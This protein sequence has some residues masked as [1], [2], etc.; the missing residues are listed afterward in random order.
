MF[1]VVWSTM[2]S[3]HRQL[4]SFLNSVNQSTSTVITKIPLAHAS[5]LHYLDLKKCLDLH[6]ARKMIDD[7]ILLIILCSKTWTLLENKLKSWS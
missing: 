3:V 2:W 7:S 1:D 5:L 4:N 6:E